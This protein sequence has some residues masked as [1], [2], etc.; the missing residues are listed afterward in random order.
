M[1][2]KGRPKWQWNGVQLSEE[3]REGMKVLKKV[4]NV[5]KAFNFKKGARWWAPE[6]SEST[7]NW[8]HFHSAQWQGRRGWRRWV[9]FWFSQEPCEP[10]RVTGVT[11]EEWSALRGAP[12]TQVPARKGLNWYTQP[13]LTQAHK[14]HTLPLDPL[15][16]AEVDLNKD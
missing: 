14:S 12:T 7:Q 13:L 9:S 4:K 3:E 2:N 11:G 1:H 15:K 16:A 6:R 10:Q 8:S 5:N